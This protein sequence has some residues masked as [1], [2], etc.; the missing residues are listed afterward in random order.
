M[1]HRRP[2][3]LAALLLLALGTAARAENSYARGTLEDPV[4]VRELAE[5]RYLDGELEAAVELYYEVAR[6]SE[7]VGERTE[8]LVNAAWLQH[9]AGDSAEAL[10]AMRSALRVD[11]DLEFDTRLF[12]PT[13]EKTYLRARVLALH[14]G[15]I[16][17]APAPRPTPSVPRES[18]AIST[19]REAISHLER[20]EE[21]RALALLQRAASLTQAQASEPELRRKALL[22]IGLL[23]YDRRQW[24]DA[25]HAF[26]EAV[27]LDRSDVSAW[28]NLGLAHS[29]GTETTR[30]IEAF[31]EAYTRHPA[32]VEN[33]HNLGH[34]LVQ[35]RSWDEAVSWMSDAVRHHARDAQLHNLLASSLS[36]RG[37]HQGAVRAWQKAMELDDEFEWKYGRQAALRLGLAHFEAGRHPEALSVA[38]TALEHDSRDAVFWNLLGLAQHAAGDAPAA[39]ESFLLA[40]DHD[41]R[42][43]EYR[44]NLGRAYAAVGDLPQAE[45]E[46]VYAL[47]LEPN[48]PAAQTN[49]AQ[50]RKLLAGS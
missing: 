23:Y 20:G 21:D 14:E 8:A 29:K 3:A 27:A 50:V 22:R 43:A 7:E 10:R 46:F 6:L 17:S 25:A 41:D 31:R 47:T 45:R 39:R 13:F 1:N 48:L 33:A 19:Y 34:A 2:F 42:R 5:G 35:A 4:Y 28:K 11:P 12:D 15:V 40:C 32:S 49:L 38:R 26:E 30:A 37:S 36:G 18:E 24:S 9:L 44:N 16:P